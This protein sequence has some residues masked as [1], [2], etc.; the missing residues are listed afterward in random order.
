MSFALAIAR[1]EWRAAFLSPVALIF[2]AI[3]LASSLFVFFFLE[4]FFAR[5]IADARPFFQ[6]MP[7]L[8]VFLAAAFT[9][10]LWS[11]EA[12]SG[13]LEILLTLPVRIRH[14]VLGKFLAG[15]ALVAVALLLTLPV[16]LTVS[17]LG[18]LDWGPVLGGYLGLLLLASAYLA[19]GMFISS[20]TDNQLVALMMSAVVCGLFVLLGYL[21]SLVPMGLLADEVLR[22][23]GTGSRFESMLR[24]VLDLRDL[25][26][27]SSLA[28][29]FLV[30]NV[31]VLEV[32]RWGHAEQGRRRR[33]NAVVFAVLLFCNLVVLNTGLFPAVGLRADLTEWGE[34][35]ISDVTRDLLRGAEEPL[36]IRGYFSHKTHPLLAPL[37]PRVRDFLRE[38]EAVGGDGLSVEFV[39]PTADEEIE[40]EAQE[41]YGVR[42]V[43]FRFS[44]RHED[45]VVNAYFHLLVR[46]GDRYEVLDY[47]DLIAIEFKGKDAHVRLRNV[48][49]DV[50]RAVQKTV[51]SFKSVE[52]ICSRLEADAR[53]KVFASS[54][55][56]PE[57][58]AEVPKR[59]EK[60]AGE[61]KHRCRRFD[62]QIVDPDDPKSPMS[63]ESLYQQ[64][65]IKPM[66][67]S[68]FDPK[69]FYMDMIVE[70]GED[71][72]VLDLGATLS[73]GEIRKELEAALQRHTPGFLKTVGL[74]AGEAAPA[75][76][77]MPPSGSSY[78]TLRKLLAQTHEVVD[79]DLKR[80]RVPG[81][82]DVLAVLNPHDLGD[83]E[84]Y[85]IDQFL[86]RGRTVIAAAGSWAFSPSMGSA[87]LDVSEVDTGLG[88]L[89]THYG[90]EVGKS[91]VLDEANARFPVPI[92][93]DYGG[94][95]MRRIEM[96]DY[97][98][99]VL[100]HGEGLSKDNPA[101]RALPALVMHWPSPVRCKG[102]NKDAETPRCETLFSS[103]DKAWQ[104]TSF[105][106]QPDFRK[107]PELGFEAPQKRERLPLAAVLDGGFTSYFKDHKP[108]VLGG[109]DKPPAGDEE[110]APEDE[111]RGHRAGVIERAPK[112]ARLVVLGSSSFVD[113]VIVEIGQQ[114]SEVHL[115]NLQLMANLVDWAVEDAALLQI[116]AKE[117]YARTLDQLSSGER[118]GWELGNFAFA[119]LAVIAIGL[120]SLIRRGQ[121]YSIMNGATESREV[122]R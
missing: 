113:D 1:K 7:V 99:F 86:M 31:L 58:L 76:P 18:D 93:E 14:L 37:V 52:S 106:A 75:Y 104:V 8:L 78:G 17:A 22:A 88:E 44:D 2:V 59:I 100:V 83:E 42:S 27:Y 48:E 97:P 63:P 30:A 116:R 23:L 33:S 62:F 109:P 84:R 28:A 92:E 105:K 119:L 121:S 56:L 35:S 40:K 77:G 13:T 20:L 108:P 90:V 65:G 50:A 118:L 80:G 66:A 16:P 19:I 68:I 67:L 21:P 60:V 34:Y 85:A 102:E 55:N 39:D 120:V 110:Q 112:T 54:K 115:A 11:E 79:V 81:S 57:E 49:Y 87:S 111:R 36:L 10:R 122:P 107:H 25:V 103:S 29:L 91:V 4:G 74:A 53:L 45:S 94:I 72:E 47:E 43:P 64:Y 9:M 101:V 114:F 26:Y 24:G 89:F 6:A 32:R 51:Y 46:Y 98:P 38:L 70:L 71:R 61:F 3:F 15:L 73:E 69:P 117:Q 95:V 12:R 82:V 41:K 96:L 5:N